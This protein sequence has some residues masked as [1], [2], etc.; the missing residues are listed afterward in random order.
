MALGGKRLLRFAAK[1]V[2]VCVD[3]A[4]HFCV[5]AAM[6][7]V[8]CFSSISCLARFSGLLFAPGFSRGVMV[9]KTGTAARFSVLSP[10]FSPCDRRARDPE[11]EKSALKR[12]AS[13]T[14]GIAFPPVKTGGK[15]EP[16]KAG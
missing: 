7:L 16:T 9:M 13:R 5:A 10:G 14:M 8:H 3:F 2:K 11:G 12:A 4:T 6:F 1:K 15:E